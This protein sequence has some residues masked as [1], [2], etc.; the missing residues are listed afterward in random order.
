MR[1]VVSLHP[2]LRIQNALPYPISTSLFA[3]SPTG[4][5]GEQLAAAVT[6]EGAVEQ[7]YCADLTTPLML[8]VICKNFRKVREPVLVFA[9]DGMGGVN[10]AKTI[11][12]LDDQGVALR[13]G[14][15]A[16]SSAWGDLTIVVYAHYLVR[17]FSHLPLTYAV[18]GGVSRSVISAAGQVP[19]LDGSVAGSPQ[20]GNTP[21]A[22]AHSGGPSFE[23]LFAGFG[24]RSSFNARM[25]RTDP[26]LADKALVNGAA[27]RGAIAVIT[28]GIVPFTEKARKAAAAGAVAVIFINT[29]DSTFLAEG[30]KGPG[31]RIPCVMLRKCDAAVIDW[32]L[33]PED[34]TTHVAPEKVNSSQRAS[35]QS[36]EWKRVV[37]ASIRFG[38]TNH[39]SS[40]GNTPDS[41]PR[42]IESLT[43]GAQAD[44]KDK[45]GTLFP[46]SWMEQP[47]EPPFIF[48]FAST[49]LTGNRACFQ[50][51]GSPWGP[52]F[53][54]E[55]V[56]TN[57]I[58]EVPG[59]PADAP[60]LKKACPLYEFGLA[61]ELGMGYLSRSKLVS[62][63]P[64]YTLLNRL[65][66]TL[67]IS[68]QGLEDEHA[69][70]LELPDGDLRP[71]HWVDGKLAKSVR[72]RV[73]PQ[74]GTTDTYQTGWSGPLLPD[75]VGTFSARL[76]NLQ[77]GIEGSRD[78]IM[79]VKVRK[80]ASFIVFRLETSAESALYALENRSSKPIKVWQEGSN[81][82]DLGLKAAPA[83]RAP[84]TWDRPHAP[85]ILV[86]AQ[87]GSQELVKVAM[88]E[89]GSVPTQAG[90]KVE[91][92]AERGSRVLR[93]TDVSLDSDSDI[94]S[95]AGEE[96]L[97]RN[98]IRVVFAGL[99]VSVLDAK[100]EEIMYASLLDF[101]LE[102]KVTRTDYEF[103]L[104]IG[105]VQ[106][107]NQTDKGPEIVLGIENSKGGE[108]TSPAVHLSIVRARQFRNMQFY[109]YFAL[110]I[111][112]LDLE[113]D[114]TFVMRILDSAQ[115][116]VDS[117]TI[118]VPD[119][120]F[121]DVTTS[122]YKQ[123]RFLGTKPVQGDKMYI[124]MLEL[125]PIVVNLSFFGTGAIMERTSTD[126]GGLSYNPM[127]AA[128][129][130]LGVVITNIDRAP[131]ALNALMLERPFAT[132]AE[133]MSCIRKHYK[134]QL[135][136]QLYKL[137]GSFEFLGNPVGLVSNLGTGMKDFFYEPA[138]GMMKSPGEFAKGMSKGTSSLLQKSTFGL[139]NAASKITGS[140]SKSLV[141]MSGD[142]DYIKKRQ[143]AQS[144]R[145]K[146]TNVN[147]TKDRQ[148]LSEQL[149]DGFMGIFAKPMAGAREGGT[150]GFFSGLGKGILGAVVKP[151][152]GLMDLTSKAA[153]GVRNTSRAGEMLRRVRP[154]RVHLGDQVLRNYDARS[155]HGCDAMRRLRDGEWKEHRYIGFCVL[156]D[157]EAV[158]V[159]DKH[160][161]V[162]AFTNHEEKWAAAVSTVK[163]IS[164]EGR[165][166]SLSVEVDVVGAAGAK[167]VVSE[168]VAKQLTCTDN[169]YAEY[170]ADVLRR[171]VALAQAASAGRAGGGRS[172][173]E[174]ML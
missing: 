161:C 105:K 74:I 174:Y 114:E 159:S 33:S 95:M 147:H 130:A 103:E 2:A 93:V 80:A 19:D 133:L 45:G 127:F 117:S 160:V 57:G 92:V 13:L 48:S 152:A 28:R 50:V 143:E 46:D 47:C 54:L 23:G 59:K 63:V 162:H 145:Q 76:P 150:A 136:Q 40:L 16:I 120:K 49:D 58:L 128:I 104:K 153:E 138:Q 69:A 108:D 135:V 73:V 110:K 3:A 1:I 55:S 123:L 64:R 11:D 66:Y 167:E 70:V 77:G 101:D 109:K 87:E 82:L 15:E 171:A 52:A 89:F 32:S 30:D 149:S 83:T 113:I 112:E 6:E 8:S 107:D 60:E 141:Q 129:K 21:D 116:V 157:G 71:F 125:H 164:V 146:K 99:C 17:N 137:V 41:R 168:A 75:Q 86:L 132:N 156:E 29:D 12:L 4:I 18:A 158:L 51:N 165:V 115:N 111:R 53:S 84:V 7:L 126:G 27:L 142:D 35:S 22:M 131:I 56:G 97:P 155:A 169:R 96:A 36:M 81:H 67:Q 9:P 31:I 85:H 78:V 122:G 65:G 62:I 61:F 151:T 100:L 79:E 42:M 10:V 88:D 91:V 121:E 5:L 68:Q 144:A 134:T 20:L 166:V 24:P 72:I 170:L 90:L 102:Y 94:V 148:D 139:F 26:P 39:S 25:V 140:M 37:K 119:E 43:G 14:V 154:P 124:E 118:T 173:N 38:D 163:D 106:V 34:L 98:A 172:N 44:P